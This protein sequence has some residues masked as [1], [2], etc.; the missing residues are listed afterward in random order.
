MHLALAAIAECT[1]GATLSVA[2]FCFRIGPTV[3]EPL[4]NCHRCK[5][6]VG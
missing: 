1:S 4:S 2:M 5:A 3:T 6:T